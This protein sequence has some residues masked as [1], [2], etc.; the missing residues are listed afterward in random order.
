[1]A[2][3][4]GTLF[5]LAVVGT[6]T[7]AV[8]RKREATAAA[9]AASPLGQTEGTGEPSDGQSEPEPE[10][11]PFQPPPLGP[12]GEQQPEPPFVPPE[13]PQPQPGTFGE[14]TGPGH[15]GPKPPVPPPFPEPQPPQQGTFG[16]PTGP[17]QSPGLGCKDIDV[18][19]TKLTSLVRYNE[20]TQVEIVISGFMPH[21][22]YQ[23]S[24]AL[25]IGTNQATFGWIDQFAE[26][27]F[28]PGQGGV[29]KEYGIKDYEYAGPGQTKLYTP[30]PK[31]FRLHYA[32][33]RRYEARVHVSTQ[34]H[35]SLSNKKA[36]SVENGSPYDACP[37]FVN[38]WP[39]PTIGNEFY[40]PAAEGPFGAS[41]S[42]WAPKPQISWVTGMHHRLVLRVRVPGIPH[43]GADAHDRAYLEPLETTRYKLFY[44]VHA[45]VVG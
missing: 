5:G 26:T 2:K 10:P 11:P 39:K 7:Y 42:S 27:N 29:P 21:C 15:P 3:P 44:A 8:F 41:A 6:A 28:G 34:G 32:Y 33:K 22:Q 24:M 25:C 19:G 36:Y 43:F 13:E 20:Q 40:I 38:K 31:K 17:G 9:Q 12:D 16:G 4:L 37:E 18:S 45:K 35:T 23:L 30:V 14:P 1:M